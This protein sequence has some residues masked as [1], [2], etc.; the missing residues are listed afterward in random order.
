MKTLA[1]F[2]I[3][4]LAK[5]GYQYRFPHDHFSHP[6]FRTEWWYW[7]GNLTDPAGRRFGFELTFFRQALSEERRAKSAWDPTDLY[8]AH[9]TLSDIQEKRF[10]HFER[11]NRAGP[12]LAGV[13]EQKGRIWNG[14]WEAGL[15]Y[16]RAVSDAFRFEFKFTSKKPPVVHGVDGVSQK[17]DGPGRASHYISFTRLMTEGKLVLGEREFQVKG[18]AWMDHEFFTHQLEREQTG[19]DWM[20][21][22]L[23]NGSELMLYRIRRSDGTVDPHS[24]GTY[25]D[26]AGNARHLN[27]TDFLMTPGRTWKRYPVAWQILVPSLDIELNAVTQLE[28]QELVAKSRF[29]PSYWEGAV[30]Y[31]GFSDHKVVGGVG[32]LEMTGY[33]RPVRFGEP[34]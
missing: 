1:A 10:L 30:D 15:G 24:A 29:S 25:V 5:P 12:G 20:S 19:W 33:D 28:D 16:A 26:A 4:A 21:I 31:A 23:D 13:D 17:A 27:A 6:E 32:Y 11:I 3:F 7:T 14:N 8:M 18:S 22:Q 9:L 34:N 2:L